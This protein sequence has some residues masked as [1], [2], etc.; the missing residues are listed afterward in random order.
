MAA[1]AEE[2]AEERGVAK[3]PLGSAER[4]HGA[5]LEAGFYARPAEGSGNGLGVAGLGVSG[6]A[7][8]ATPPQQH[9][10]SAVA[11]A[12]A[13]AAAAAAAAATPTT[14]DEVRYLERLAAAAA[15]HAAVA[16]A[17]AEEREV[18]REERT[19]SLT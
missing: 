2:R 9:G 11:V 18:I 8:Q 15:R 14:P 19:L 10:A 3:P 6:F 16:E 5:A 13:A 1:R 7:P 17:R 4:T 12:V